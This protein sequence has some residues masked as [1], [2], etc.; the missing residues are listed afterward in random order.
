MP[1][2]TARKNP[3]PFYARSPLARGLPDRH[4]PRKSLV[5]QP[6]YLEKSL[7][8]SPTFS[9]INLKEL[10]ESDMRFSLG[11]MYFSR[12]YVSSLLFASASGDSRMFLFS[13]PSPPRVLSS[14]DFSN[15]A[16]SRFHA[17]ARAPVR[18]VNTDGFGDPS[19]RFDIGGE[20]GS[21]RIARTEKKRVHG[22][23]S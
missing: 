20:R 6:S 13:S 12:A 23:T 10:S 3:R 1:R 22:A 11:R 16:L 17:F 18:N 8:L 15:L 5:N 19:R 21:W 14:T 9:R 4:S 2:A 7:S